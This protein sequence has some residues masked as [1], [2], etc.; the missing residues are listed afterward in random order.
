MLMLGPVPTKERKPTPNVTVVLPSGSWGLSP[1]MLTARSFW[2][3][4]LL[5]LKVALWVGSV[6]SNL[7]VVL[8]DPSV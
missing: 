4:T 1:L 6:G 3:T 2:A 8:N 5:S 7:P